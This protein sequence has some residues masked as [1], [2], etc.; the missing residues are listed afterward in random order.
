VCLLCSVHLLF[1]NLLFRLLLDKLSRFQEEDFDSDVSSDDGLD[2]IVAP[3]SSMDV[4]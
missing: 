1:I 4:K 2:D 3:S